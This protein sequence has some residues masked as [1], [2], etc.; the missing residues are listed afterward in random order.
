MAIVIAISSKCQKLYTRN[1]NIL[2]T[3]DY[4]ECQPHRHRCTISLYFLY[5][6]P[7]YSSIYLSIA[8]LIKKSISCIRKP[9][10]FYSQGL[11]TTFI[12]Y[13][14]SSSSYTLSPINMMNNRK[15]ETAKIIMLLRV[16]QQKRIDFVIKLTAKRNGATA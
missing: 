4:I 13:S 7:Y 6:F 9:C 1:T 5:H 2:H 3:I 14:S 10:F 12:S 15:N 11:R 8:K 16:L